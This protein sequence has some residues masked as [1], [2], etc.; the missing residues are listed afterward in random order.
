MKLF[1]DLVSTFLQILS[2]LLYDLLDFP[3]VNLFIRESEFWYYLLWQQISEI[4]IYQILMFTQIISIGKIHLV[5]HS[6]PASS[7]AS[8]LYIIL[9]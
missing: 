9:C 2:F 3:G 6:I 5:L 7:F 1:F 8:L 4:F